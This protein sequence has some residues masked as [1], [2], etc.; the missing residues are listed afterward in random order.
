M[1]NERTFL[2]RCLAIVF[3]FQFSTVLY[4]TVSCNGVAKR[5]DRE[6][7]IELFCNKASESLGETG[8]MSMTT[9]LALMVPSQKQYEGD[10]EEKEKTEG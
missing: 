2:L 7:E 8:K 9:I 5:S 4:W 3:L 1:K 10:P 6:T